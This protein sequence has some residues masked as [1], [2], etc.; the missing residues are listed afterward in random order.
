MDALVARLRALDVRLEASGDVL[1]YDAPRHVLVPDLLA[2]LK[3][4]KPELL[5]CLSGVVEQAPVSTQQEAMLSAVERSPRPQ[6]YSVGARLRFTGRLDVAAL[7]RAVSE[8]VARHVGLRSRFVRDRDGQW[9]QQALAID[10]VPLAVEDLRGH[11]AAVVEQ[12][13]REAADTAFDLG[14]SS[15]PMC[16]LLRVDEDSWVLMFVTHHIST[17]GWAQLVVFRELAELYRAATTGTEPCL[18]LPGLQAT[19]YARWQRDRDC[20]KQWLDFW[21]EHLRG[22]DLLAVVPTDHPRSVRR[23]GAGN[24]VRLAVPRRIR[25]SVEEFA[26][27]R[28]VT[29]FAVLAAALGRWLAELSGAEDVLIPVS[30]ANRGRRELETLVTCARIPLGLLVRTPARVSFTVLVDQVH[31]DFLA[32]MDNPIP[33]DRVLPEPRDDLVGFAFQNLPG[34]EV[35]FPGLSTRIDDVA[36][37]ATRSD[38][39]FGL[40]PS[41]DP[42]FGYQAWLEHSTDLWDPATGNSLLQSYLDS[43][44]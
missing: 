4:H 6:V 26:R 1:R 38:M 41:V 11:G 3:R 18:T 12:V 5:A 32:A 25:T 2:E 10:S 16:R 39:T 15:V 31:A 42:E 33:V 29:A 17:D 28:G 21:S 24:T 19:D 40:V 37:T 14:R 9:V 8:V 13:C 35:A 30:Y 34:P 23:T 20:P 36:S 7:R 27:S 22:A 43:L 44:P